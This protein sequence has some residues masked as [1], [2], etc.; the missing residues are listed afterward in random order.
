VNR[1][2]DKANYW[3]KL[4][5]FVALALLPVVGLALLLA[6][7]YA[8]GPVV[9]LLVVFGALLILALPVGKF[10]LFP[11][12]TLEHMYRGWVLRRISNSPKS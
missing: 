10:M 2:D 4:A 12:T 1:Q 7:I 9:Y 5:L 3:S 11:N 6:A 8:R